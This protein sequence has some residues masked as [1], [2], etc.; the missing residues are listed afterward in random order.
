MLTLAVN[1]SRKYHLQGLFS[2]PARYKPTYPAFR[3]RD[4]PACPDGV[5][6]GQHTEQSLQTK[7]CLLERLAAN[8]NITFASR[9]V[10]DCNISSMQASLPSPTACASCA[11]LLVT[12]RNLQEIVCL[13]TFAIHRPVA[14]LPSAGQR[15]LTEHKGPGQDS[16]SD[17]P[18]VF[19]GRLVR[20]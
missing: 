14:G 13:G 15:F 9:V 3:S 1:G 19:G 20:L 7:S 10:P 2:V 18:C 16:T 6:C 8:A 5:A 11:Q 17:L 12:P 4:A